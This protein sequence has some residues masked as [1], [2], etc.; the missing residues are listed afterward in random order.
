[1]FRNF[2]LAEVHPDALHAAEAAESV[3]AQ[4]GNDA[5]WLMHDVLFEH[6]HALDD[7]ALARYAASSGANAV[8]TLADL[9]AHA[10]QARVRE[11]FLGGVRSGVNGTPTFFING[12]RYDGDWLNIEEFAKA[13]SRPK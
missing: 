13:L 3:G 2:P 9:D 12:E 11:D 1:M 4:V 8:Q 6:Q 7:A 10:Y 5:Y